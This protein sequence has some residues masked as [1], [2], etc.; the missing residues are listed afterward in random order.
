SRNLPCRPVPTIVR[1]ANAS[2]GGSNVFNAA[3]ATSS[4][5]SITCPVAF[6][7]RNDT[8]ACTSGSSGIL[9]APLPARRP[10]AADAPLRRRQLIDHVE[11]RVLHPLDHQ[12]GDA[13]APFHLVGLHRIGVHQ[14]HAH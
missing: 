6:S 13:V 7:A 2:N 9:A 11:V 5:R 4:A 12:L 10:E 1:P 3:K 14:Q 8:S